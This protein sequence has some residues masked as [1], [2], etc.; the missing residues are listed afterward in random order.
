MRNVLEYPELQSHGMAGA[1]RDGGGARALNARNCRTN[2]KARLQPDESPP[3]DDPNL[4][5]ARHFVNPE[6]RWCIV[7]LRGPER[8][9]HKKGGKGASQ[10]PVV[11]RSLAQPIR[12]ISRT[13]FRQPD[14]NSEPPL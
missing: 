2:K 8:L 11:I 3:Y 13:F 6:F 14:A 4:F 5:Q 1:A 7:P 10:R 12:H 9:R